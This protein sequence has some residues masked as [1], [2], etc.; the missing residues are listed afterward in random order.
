[1][2][3]LCEVLAMTIILEDRKF[4]WE[5]NDLKTFREMWKRG[6]SIKNIARRF[7]C[8]EIDIALLVLDQAEKGNIEARKSGLMGVE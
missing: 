6:D 2:K 7:K 1:M 5:Q 4:I 3:W 8:K